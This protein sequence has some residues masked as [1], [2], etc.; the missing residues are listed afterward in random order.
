MVTQSSPFPS[1]PPSWRDFQIYRLVKVERCSTRHAARSL[2]VSQTRVCQILNR[3]GE[4]LG[5]LLLATD[6]EEGRRRDLLLAEQL[7]AEMMESFSKQAVLAWK[8][9]E[10][11]TISLPEEGS[12]D[13]EPRV[14]RTPGN[15]RYL[16]AAA[17]IAECQAKLPTPKLATLCPPPEEIDEADDLPLRNPFD[18]SIT[19]LPEQFAEL[20][21]DPESPPVEDC[22]AAAPARSVTARKPSAAT[23][24]TEDVTGTCV[25]GVS[26]QLLS[27]LGQ[28]V[29]VQP[30][31]E[32]PSTNSCTKASRSK[33]Q[34]RRAFFGS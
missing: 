34:A 4:Y 23:A 22:S 25:S 15:I 30:P 19:D 11:V 33:Q 32:A 16:L 8:R 13:E 9:S 14:M 5:E 3:V 2:Q 29:P 24:S 26:P 10:K 12:E 21:E 1:L 7:A 20:E 28:G 18:A 31:R 17:K 6:S 27:K